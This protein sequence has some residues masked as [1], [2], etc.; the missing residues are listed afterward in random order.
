M[1]EEL[2]KEVIDLK[3]KAHIFDKRKSQLDVYNGKYDL[4]LNKKLPY[5]KKI[6]K[7]A[8]EPIAYYLHK[9]NDFLKRI[10]KHNQ[11]KDHLEEREFQETIKSILE[12]K[13]LK[14]TMHRFHQRQSFLKRASI[15][16]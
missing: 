6:E 2:F 9:K 8:Q 15:Q 14:N 10:E 5:P 11:N 16:A 4:K 1:K 12:T 13:N 3:N 7:F